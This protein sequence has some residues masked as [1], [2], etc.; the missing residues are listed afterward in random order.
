MI[1]D[2]VDTSDFHTIQSHVV[3]YYKTLFGHGGITWAL[4]QLMFGMKLSG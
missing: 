3:Q 1:I 2:D 4:C